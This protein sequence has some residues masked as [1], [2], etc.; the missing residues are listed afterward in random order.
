MANV[1]I[2]VGELYAVDLPNVSSFSSEIH[3]WYTKWKSEEKDHGSNSFPSTLS[4]LTRISSFYPNIKALVT[5]LCTLPVTSCITERSFNGLKRIK[6]VLRSSMSNERLLSL[7]LLHVHQDIPIDIEE[8]TDE[9]SIRNPRRIKLS[10]STQWLSL[11]CVTS[12]FPY[13]T[14]EVET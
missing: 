2:K 7:T 9:F 10:G 1:V 5:F 6:T 8:V 14:H 11:Y 13:T 4:T 12:Y 3:K